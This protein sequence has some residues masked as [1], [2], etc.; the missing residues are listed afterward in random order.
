[1]FLKHDFTLEAQK[2]SVCNCLLHNFL[3]FSSGILNRWQAICGHFRN[4]RFALNKMFQQNASKFAIFYFQANS[5]GL[6]HSSFLATLQYECPDLCHRAG[7]SYGKNVKWHKMKNE[8]NYMN[9][10]VNKIQQKFEAFRW[11]ILLSTNLF[12][13]KSVCREECFKWNLKMLVN[14]NY[15]KERFFSTTK[16]LDTFLESINFMM[17]ISIVQKKS[18]TEEKTWLL[19]KK[20]KI[21]QKLQ[22]P[23]SPFL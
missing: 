2:F 3:D 13:L 17:Y 20:K 1:M 21:I 6:F 9:L 16:W 8:I 7:Y 11:N 19:V 4:K 10:S 15:I 18:D 5:C 23:S 22:Q 14:I 12:F